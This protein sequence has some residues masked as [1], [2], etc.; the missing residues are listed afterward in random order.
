MSRRLDK[1]QAAMDTC[2]LDVAFP[3]SSK[4]LPEIGGV[5][6]LDILDNWVPAAEI[7]ISKQFQQYSYFLSHLPSI[8]VNLVTITGGVDNVQPKAYA[9]LFDDCQVGDIISI[10]MYIFANWRGGNVLWETA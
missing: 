3:L 9:V 5:L 2:I 1:E 7:R 10:Y 4:F 8:I 6:I